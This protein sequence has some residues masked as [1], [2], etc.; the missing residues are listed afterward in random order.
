MH[1]AL[2]VRN[3]DVGLRA[4]G[5]DRHARQHGPGAVLDG[6]VDAACVDLC[7]DRRRDE[8]RADERQANQDQSCLHP[9][10]LCMIR[11]ETPPRRTNA[12]AG[13]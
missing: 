5:L 4:D 1:F 9:I 7:R 12:G 6:D 10:L 3:G 13:D 11:P 8:R 2:A